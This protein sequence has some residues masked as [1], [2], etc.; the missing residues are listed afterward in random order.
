MPLSCLLIGYEHT[1]IRSMTEEALALVRY[2]LCISLGGFVCVVD[3]C[4]VFLGKV[5]RE[6][7][8]TY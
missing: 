2:E 8:G 5:G 7:L 4:R 6:L 3:V 1:L